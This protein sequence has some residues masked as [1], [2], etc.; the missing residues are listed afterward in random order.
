[1]PRENPAGNLPFKLRIDVCPSGYV[2]E[3]SGGSAILKVA[4]SAEFPFGI[5]V[6]NL[7]A[8]CRVIP[9]W[10]WNTTTYS[11]AIFLSTCNIMQIENMIQQQLRQSCFV[12]Q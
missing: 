12:N 11:R 2:R 4:N 6:R 8:E 5:V 3:E 7:G 1:M 9:G 10:E